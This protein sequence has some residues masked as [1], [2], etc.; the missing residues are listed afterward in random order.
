MEELTFNDGVFFENFGKEI[1]VSIP[2]G[3][4][5]LQ[6][7]DDNVWVN[8]SFVVGN[9]QEHRKTLERQIKLNAFYYPNREYRI[10]EVK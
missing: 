3:S 4:L 2:R 8:I 10:V 9:T 5:V 7:L 1:R 6:M